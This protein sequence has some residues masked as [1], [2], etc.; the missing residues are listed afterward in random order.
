[1]RA[2]RTGTKT[3]EVCGTTFNRP[4]NYSTKQWEE[5]R[6]CGRQCGA[7]IRSEA[8]REQLT[9]ECSDC[10]VVGKIRRDGR[11]QSCHSAWRWANDPEHRAKVQARNQAW[12]RANREYYRDRYHREKD[13][14]TARI[15]LN[16]ALKMGRVTREPCETCSSTTDVEGHHDDYTRPLDVRWL[17]TVCHAAEHRMQRRAA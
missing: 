1:M 10:R 15:A 16:G 8:L 9:G 6:A 17:C 5:R 13:K 4:A 14:C 11:C 3:C 2:K 7:V 12:V